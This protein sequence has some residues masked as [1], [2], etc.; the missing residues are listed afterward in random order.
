MQSVDSWKV[1]RKAFRKM[2]FTGVLIH[3]TPVDAVFSFTCLRPLV[4][5]NVVLDYRWLEQE[6][7]LKISWFFFFCD[8]SAK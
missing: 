1:A 2:K 3:K 5:L 8:V 7:I 4:F 6:E